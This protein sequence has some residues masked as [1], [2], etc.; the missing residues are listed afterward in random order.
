AF[1][2]VELPISLHQFRANCRVVE[3][4]QSAGSHG[5]DK[6]LM[7]QWFANP[8]QVRRAVVNEGLQRGLAGVEFGALVERDFLHRIE[9]AAVAEEYAQVADAI[10][11]SGVR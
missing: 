3:T 9:R 2:R 10:A 7:K 1:G 8:S 4:C 5:I 11:Q 6:L